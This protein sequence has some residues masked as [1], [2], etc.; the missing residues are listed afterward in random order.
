MKTYEK[1][2]TRTLEGLRKAERLLERG[3]VTIERRC[4]I[5]FVT[6]KNPNVPLNA[7]EL[8]DKEK[9]RAI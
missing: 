4:D 8:E 6:L 7:G 3:W 9:A 5:T 2:D 1:I